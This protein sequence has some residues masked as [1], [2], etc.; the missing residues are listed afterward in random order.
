MG[1]R[2]IELNSTRAITKTEVGGVPVWRLISEQTSPMG[3]AADTFDIDAK[4][5]MPIHRSFSQGPITAQVTY[6]ANAA[7]GVIKMGTNE[8][9][10]DVSFPA[11]VFGDDAALETALIALPLKP[12]YKTTYRMFNTQ[13]QKVRLMSLEVTGT[14]NVTVPAGTFD[15]FKVEIK[16]LDGETGGGGTV[17][18][19]EDDPRCLVRGTFQL[20]A[21]AGGG[22]LTAELTSMEQ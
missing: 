13:M 7:K 6:T 14:E 12:G 15:V 17:F 11:P 2:E 10:V 5:L 18:V 19:S 8:M 21:S 16:P 22:T 1:G 3:S 9:P 4:T 20:P